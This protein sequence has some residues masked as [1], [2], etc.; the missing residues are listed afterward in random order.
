MR[1]KKRKIIDGLSHW[2][3]PGCKKWLLPGEYNCNKNTK[4]GLQS[5]CRECQRTKNWNTNIIVT[6][7]VKEGLK[8]FGCG[9]YFTQKNG[10]FAVCGDCFKHPKNE[11]PLSKYLET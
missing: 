9:V 2:F 1:A 11:L 3:C 7:A 10:D 8:C 6:E 4:N 5:Y